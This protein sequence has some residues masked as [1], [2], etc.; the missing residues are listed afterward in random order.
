M[1]IFKISYFVA[2]LA[3][4]MSVQGIAQNEKA[5]EYYLLDSINLNQ[6]SS[7]ELNLLDSC[8]AVF[9]ASENDTTKVRSIEYFID[10]TP[11]D[12][13]LYLYSEWLMRYTLLSLDKPNEAEVQKVL[14]RCLANAMDVRGS[15][16]YNVVGDITQANDLFNK[17]L[18]L[19]EE[20]GNAAGQ[21]SALCNIGTMQYEINEVDLALEYFEKSL[22]LQ[23]AY[24]DSSLL[25]VLY[26]NI[27]NCYAQL[28]K[29]E[30][31]KDY[32]LQ[33]TPFIKGEE[34]TYHYSNLGGISLFLGDTLGALGHY[35]KALEINQNTGSAGMY[36]LALKNIGFFW[37][38]VAETKNTG[39]RKETLQK[40]EDYLSKGYDI[41]IAE[42][43]R[44][45]KAE[46]ALNLSR[47]FKL[48]NRFEEALALYETYVVLNDSIH[49]NEVKREAAQ[50]QARYEFEKAALI[51]EQ[52]E[53]EKARIEEEMLQRRNNL[54]Y[55]IIFIT[56]LVAF[57]SVLALGFIS[58]SPTLAD[59]LIFFAF[60]LFFEF[61]LVLADPYVEQWT[62]GAPGWKL[63]I[64]SAI[65]A[66]IFPL[67]GFFERVLKE[68]IVR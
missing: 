1:K 12:T 34:L 8:L 55:S 51:K 68:K 14:K 64:N 54:Q 29:L 2:I 4:S 37:L 60:L 17:A 32:F 33:A 27:G 5:G 42:G 48:Q 6:S 23:L 38:A 20:I 58:I 10:N 25:D 59:G 45:R 40:A 52:E 26:S 65:A 22:N 53:K 43:Y 47:V 67:H 7:E 31:A 24:S 39:E 46:F 44:R 57:G 63:L 9:H 19:H 13:L 16:Y 30:K 61:L 21:A 35:E 11:G 3:V 50:Q 66:G 36:L 15:Y 28:G 56:I 18:L 41:S 49:G 62:G